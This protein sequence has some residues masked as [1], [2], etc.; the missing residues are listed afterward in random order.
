MDFSP[1]KCTVFSIFVGILFYLSFTSNS[2]SSSFFKINKD[3]NCYQTNDQIDYQVGPQQSLT[4]ISEVPW[5]TLQPGDRVYIH[6]KDTP[7]KEKWVI[8]RQGTEDQ[9]IEII[10]VN[11]PQGQQPVIDGND[12]VTVSGV[13][14]W[15]EERGV[16]KIGG[17]NVPADGLPGYITIENL[18]IRSGR[19]P[20]QFTNDNGQTNTYS[21]NAAGI[22]VEKATN[23][24]IK[25]CTI[26]DSGNGL[27]IAGN[28]GNMQNIMVKKIISM[29]MV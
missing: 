23:L 28:N 17:S 29:T 24:I 15:N 5:A 20:Y 11:G 26:H 1:N 25:N 12:A 16:I 14:Y 22:Y 4:T 9:R 10:G 27:F 19:P 7:Y 3:F 21:D 8:N 6:W 2:L 18:E 13:N